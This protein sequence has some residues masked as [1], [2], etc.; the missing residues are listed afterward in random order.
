MSAVE[1][2]VRIETTAG[3]AQD[4]QRLAHELVARRLVACAQVLGPIRS[5]YRWEGAVH[6]DEEHLLVLK[7]RAALVEDVK[8]AVDELHPYDVPELVVV[9]VTDG[10]GAYLDW[11][12][13][14][15]AGA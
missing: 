8:A 6:D 3:S 4:A 15:T 13:A 7:T 9:A 11:I 2:H 1:G 5:V 12:D 10:S 14:Q